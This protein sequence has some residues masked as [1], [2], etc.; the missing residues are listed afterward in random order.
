MQPLRGGM[1][2]VPINN[3]KVT[4]KSGEA[5]ASPGKEGRRIITNE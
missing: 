4:K 5:I 3:K 2:D 1:A